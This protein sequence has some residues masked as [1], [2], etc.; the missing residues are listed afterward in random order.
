MVNRGG[1]TCED[2]LRV[3]EHVRDTVLNETGFLLEPEVR[4]LGV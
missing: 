3:M 1:A 2:V 4:I